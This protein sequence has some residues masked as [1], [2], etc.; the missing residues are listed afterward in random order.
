MWVP[1]R[2][3]NLPS[4]ERGILIPKILG[5]ISYQTPLA[6]ALLN[7]KPGDEVEF[8]TDGAK[9]RFPGGQH[10]R[11]EDGLTVAL[12]RRSNFQRQNPLPCGRGY[13]V[14]N[15]ISSDQSFPP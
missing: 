10:R 6:Q 8:D 4:L 1:A 15:Y 9:R 5:V 7:H 3:N 14:S 11:V 2:L 13:I 12:F